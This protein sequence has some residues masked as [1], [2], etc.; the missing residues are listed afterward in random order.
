MIGEEKK[1]NKIKEQ[2]NI[3]VMVC[4]VVDWLQGERHGHEERKKEE[5]DF[6]TLDVQ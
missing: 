4:F 3:H 6:R 2:Y 5:E 1:Y